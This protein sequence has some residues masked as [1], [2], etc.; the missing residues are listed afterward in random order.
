MKTGKYAVALLL[1]AAA[2]ASGRAFAQGCV[3]AHSSQHTMDE[4]VT[5]LNDGASGGFNIHNLILN[6]GYR[7]F[8]SNKYFVG[9]DEIAR[10]TAVRN[11]QNIFDIGVEYRLSPRFSLVADVPVFNGTRDQIYP[12]SGVYQVSGVG[13]LTVGVQS[14]IFR[15]PTENGGNIAVSMSLKIPTGIDN[16][17]GSA[18]YQG[19]II[20]ATADQS[21]QPGDGGWGALLATQAYKSFWRTSFGYLQGQYLSNPMD[22]NGVKTFRTQPGQG[23]M[24]ITDQYLWRAGLSQGVPKIRHLAVS[25]GIRDEGVP[26]HDL[27][28]GNDGF[29][30]PGYIISLDPGVMYSYHRDVISING[31]WALARNRE[32]SVPE[33]QNH[34]YNGDAFF[35]DYTIVASVS[36]HF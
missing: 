27:I 9:T 35:A 7:V 30:R 29:R 33:L 26:A 8:N 13:D 2:A 1:A 10:P 3:A 15:P 23:V 28:G 19:Q 32:P 31:P 11:H 6:I 20:K 5:D 36:H 34:I 22:T 24:S 17:T 16:A 12:P 14:W 18:L 25:L 21:M 4:L